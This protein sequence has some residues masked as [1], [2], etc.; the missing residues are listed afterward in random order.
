MV[1]DIQFGRSTQLILTQPLLHSQLDE[2]SSVELKALPCDLCNRHCPEVV[3]HGN[4]CNDTQDL[5][6]YYHK[7]N[8]FIIVPLGA[9]VIILIAATAPI[10]LVGARDVVQ[11]T[12]T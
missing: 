5:E 1:D 6:K 7:H 8:D 11:L 12:P 4:E 9:S 3:Y 10:E 2:L